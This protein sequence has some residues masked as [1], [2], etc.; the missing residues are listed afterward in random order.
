MKRKRNALE[1]GRD[2]VRFR[3]ALGDQHALL[4]Q[5]GQGKDRLRGPDGSK[6]S[7]GMQR[8]KKEAGPYR[9]QALARSHARL[10][11][12]RTDFWPSG[13]DRWDPRVHGTRHRKP[14]PSSHFASRVLGSRGSLVA[15]L[16]SVAAA[17]RFR[18]GD[19]R[20]ISRNAGPIGT[21]VSAPWNT[22]RHGRS[23]AMEP[24]TD[25]QGQAA[26]RSR[27]E[28]PAGTDVLCHR[29]NHKADDRVD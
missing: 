24:S 3:Y 14:K 6:G 11:Q 10:P 8:G 13:T 5:K 1:I 18:S 4:V 15:S 26:H 16:N 20:L 25:T 21:A 22:P 7:I 29:R 28:R 12:M 2:Y 9:T 19:Q 17:S 27:F 23:T